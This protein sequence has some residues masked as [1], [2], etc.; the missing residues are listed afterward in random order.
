MIMP[1]KIRLKVHIIKYIILTFCYIRTK[2]LL[3]IQNKP[4]IWILTN[5]NYIVIKIMLIALSMAYSLIL[6]LIRKF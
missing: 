1:G 2:M 3:S 6:W 5:I 4:D